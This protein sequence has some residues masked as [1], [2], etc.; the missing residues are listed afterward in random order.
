MKSSY[1]KAFV[2]FAALVLLS[3]ASISTAFASSATASQNPDLTVSVSATSTNAN[4]DLV[5]VGD[6]ETII[7]A[8]K[9]NTTHKLTVQLVTRL[10]A[11][12]GFT[13]TIAV[14]QVTLVPG[15]TLSSSFTYTDESSFPT[16]VY[17]AKFSATDSKGTSSATTSTTLI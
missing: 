4:P 2:I 13:A 12:N 10:T 11:P 3:L 7:R 6:Q 8:V 17:S 1:V 5:A 15:Q 16:G 9:N 14:Q